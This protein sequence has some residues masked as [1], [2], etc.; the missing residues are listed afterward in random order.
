MKEVNGRLEEYQKNIQHLI[1]NMNLWRPQGFK[2][3]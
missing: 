1:N 2:F 3:S